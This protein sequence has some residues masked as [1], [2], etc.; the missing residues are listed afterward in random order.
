MDLSLLVGVLWQPSLAT[1]PKIGLAYR[2]SDC[3]QPYTLP[4]PPKKALIYQGFFSIFC[5]WLCVLA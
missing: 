4:C 1:I 5:L 3:A 2:T